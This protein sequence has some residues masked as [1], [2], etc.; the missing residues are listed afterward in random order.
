M[1][2]I[3]LWARQGNDKKYG[4]VV[5][6]GIIQDKDTWS[7]SGDGLTLGGNPGSS[8]QSVK[9]DL[10]FFYGGYDNDVNHSRRFEFPRC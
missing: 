7:F 8:D 3:S 10:F 1:L 9:V 5:V 6:D 4:L 2:A